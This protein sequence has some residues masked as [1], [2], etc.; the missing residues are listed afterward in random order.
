VVHPDAHRAQQDWC[1]A[2]D[3]ADPLV[4]ALLEQLQM[5]GSSQAEQPV[6]PA[7]VDQPVIS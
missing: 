7:G 1:R 3:G 5:P 4:L 6:H 2:V